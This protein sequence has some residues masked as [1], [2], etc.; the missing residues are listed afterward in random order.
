MSDHGDN[1]DSGREKAIDRIVMPERQRVEEELVKAKLE[2]ERKLTSQSHDIHLLRAAVDSCSDGILILDSNG[3]VREYN[4]R[5][6]ELLLIPGSVLADGDQATVFSAFSGLFED[7]DQIRARFDAIGMSSLLESHDV[8]QD[9]HGR[10]LSF[11]SLIQIAE[12]TVIGRVWNIRLVGDDAHSGPR[13][14][15]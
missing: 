13:K 1:L 11:T 3:L 12:G 14:I 9:K 6:L 5:L 15:A 8:F 7:C 10:V 2:T 4:R